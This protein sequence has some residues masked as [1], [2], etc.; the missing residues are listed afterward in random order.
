MTD[1]SP[2]L[3]EPTNPWH[4]G[5]SESVADGLAF[6][7]TSAASLIRTGL[8]DSRNGVLMSQSIVDAIKAKPIV[9]NGTREALKSLSAKLGEA[10]EMYTKIFALVAKDYGDEPLTENSTGPIDTKPAHLDKGDGTE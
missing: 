2:E 8:Q 1:K 5:T 7:S 3:Q 6:V 9:Q 4:R 10:E